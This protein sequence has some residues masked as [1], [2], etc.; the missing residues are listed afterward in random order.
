MK[1]LVILT[2]LFTFTGIS[3]QTVTIRDLKSG[4]LS[5]DSTFVYSLPYPSGKSYLLVQ[6][7]QSSMSHKGE[8]ALDFKM[9]PGTRICAA[10]GGVVVS[11]R[12]DSEKGGLKPEMLSEGNHI[13]IQHDDGSQGMYWHLKKD[14]VLVAV[15]DTIKQD[16][17]IGFSGN[18]GYTAFPHL[19]FE[20]MESSGGQIPTRFRTRKGIKYL[21]PLKWHKAI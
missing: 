9:K 15:G 4:R 3:A 12:E 8:Y 1:Y 18:T 17:V 5:D 19:H 16:Q 20:V 11:I 2:S 13:I 6:A 7:Y 10:R 21:R 14:G